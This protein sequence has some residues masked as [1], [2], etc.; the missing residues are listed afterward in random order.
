MGGNA[1]PQQPQDDR[2]Y[3]Q[4]QPGSNGAQAQ[5]PQQGTPQFTREQGAPQFTRGIR[6]NL[7]SNVQPQQGGMSAKGGGGVRPGFQ[8][9]PQNPGFQSLLG[10]NRK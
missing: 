6:Q 9:Q 8:F 1:Q 5:Q 7:F 10:Q 2:Q 3:Q 4:V